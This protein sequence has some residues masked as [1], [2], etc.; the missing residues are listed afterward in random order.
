MCVWGGGVVLILGLGGVAVFEG[1]G[2]IFK[3]C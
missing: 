2:G 3:F 1:G